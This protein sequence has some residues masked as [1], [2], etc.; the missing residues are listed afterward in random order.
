MFLPTRWVNSACS[1][2]D[3]TFEIFLENIFRSSKQ[4]RDSLSDNESGRELRAKSRFLEEL[5]S[6]SRRNLIEEVKR[7]VKKN[8]NLMQRNEEL[9]KMIGGK[10]K[11]TKRKILGFSKIPI[12]KCQQVDG[13]KKFE[14][15]NL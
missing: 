13:D 3:R 15:K 6:M 10:Q 7:H 12:R 1:F 2:G 5:D 14:V 9:E 4:R 8:R 11:D